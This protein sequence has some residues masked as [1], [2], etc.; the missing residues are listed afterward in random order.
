M[1]KKKKGGKKGG[2]K[3]KSADSAEGGLS[4]S[5]ENALL[6]T[7]IESLKNELIFE[8]SRYSE[9]FTAMKEFRTHYELLSKEFEEEKS[10]TFIITANMTRQ[11][12]LMRDELMKKTNDLSR[13]L[14]QKCLEIE[15]L[16]S[17][18]QELNKRHQF[19]L[20]NKDKK[21]KM[22]QSKLEEMSRQFGSML[23]QT[24]DKM[25]EKIVVNNKDVIAMSSSN[26]DKLRNLSVAFQNNAFNK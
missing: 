14:D 22:M 5:D 23:R 13:N 21:I 2:K 25:A 17:Q 20:E 24:L 15:E 6:K 9:A 26:L 11:Y 3:T 18:Q 1:A 16:H 19:E 8:K 4:I 7:Q 10:K 12:K